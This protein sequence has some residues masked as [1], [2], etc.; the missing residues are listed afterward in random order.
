ML[1]ERHAASGAGRRSRPSRQRADEKSDLDLEVC[2]LALALL[3]FRSFGAFAL[4]TPPPLVIKASRG[5]EEDE[6]RI[7]G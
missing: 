6:E 2:D 3:P 4:V 1:G 5:K 7:N